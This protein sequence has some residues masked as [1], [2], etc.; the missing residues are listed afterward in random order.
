MALTWPAKKCNFSVTASALNLQAPKPGR[1]CVVQPSSR[2]PTGEQKTER[3]ARR[4]HELAEA[5]V[6]HSAHR[7]LLRDSVSRLPN[8][9][10]SLQLCARGNSFQC[11]GAKA[12]LESSMTVFSSV[13]GTSACRASHDGTHTQSARSMIVMPQRTR[14]SRSPALT[15]PS[16]LAQPYFPSS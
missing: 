16:S 8:A 5:S 1:R 9:Q 15:P 2:R 7:R 12:H 10:T 3:Q 11:N 6:P 13:S 4:P 14:R